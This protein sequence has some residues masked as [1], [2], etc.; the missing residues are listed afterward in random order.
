MPDITAHL[1]WAT[2]LGK[3]VAREY[4]FRKGGQ[5]EDDIISVAFLHLH[6]CGMRYTGRSDDVDHFRGYAYPSLVAECRREARRLRNGG[7]YWTRKEQRGEVIDVPALSDLA[8]ADGEPFDAAAREEVAC[9][10]A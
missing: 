5:E 6:R 7:T 10:W 3:T 2:K 8:N 1:G 4:H 9:L